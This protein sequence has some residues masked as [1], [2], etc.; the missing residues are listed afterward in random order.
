MPYGERSD[1]HA[2]NPRRGAGLS[3]PVAA[4]KEKQCGAHMNRIGAFPVACNLNAHSG[5][6]RDLTFTD[7]QDCRCTA[8][9]LP[10]HGEEVQEHCYE[11][12]RDGNST[13]GE[14]PAQKLLALICAVGQIPICYRKWGIDACNGGF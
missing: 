14:G 12:S 5:H 11:A 1:Q 3:G 10:N 13:E 4:H 2:E 8:K 6:V 7:G 9:N